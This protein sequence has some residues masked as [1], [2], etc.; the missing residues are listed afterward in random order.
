MVMRISLSVVSGGERF[1]RSGDMMV[2]S[3]SCSLISFFR[4]VRRELR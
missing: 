3:L 4:G 1:A 2:R